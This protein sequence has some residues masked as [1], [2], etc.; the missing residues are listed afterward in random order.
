MYI[1]SQQTKLLGRAADCIELNMTDKKA[2]P[3]NTLKEM[4][5]MIS[6]DASVYIDTFF[7]QKLGG[8][9][10]DVSYDRDAFKVNYHGIQGY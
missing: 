1:P 5:T 7:L 9:G 3:E 2:K 10:Y 8:A 6:V 4:H